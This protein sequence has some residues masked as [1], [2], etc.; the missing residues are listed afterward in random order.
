MYQAGW[1]QKQI[2]EAMGVTK[3]AVSQW[4]KVGKAGGGWLS[5]G[6]RILIPHLSETG[7]NFEQVILIPPC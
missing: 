7:H 2:A 4:I 6:K 5:Q 3:G 1:P